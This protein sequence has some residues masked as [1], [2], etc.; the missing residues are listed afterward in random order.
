ML[1]MVEKFKGFFADRTDVKFAVMYGSAAKDH[2]TE[3]SD[4]DIAIASDKEFEIEQLEEISEALEEVCG[5]AIDLVDMG[6]AGSA[7]IQEILSEG[8]VLRNDPDIY[9]KVTKLIW[10]DESAI[11]NGSRSHTKQKRRRSEYQ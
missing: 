11:G 8:I 5:R 3:Y 4:V 9:A 7:L 10:Y 6:S 2:L 1:A